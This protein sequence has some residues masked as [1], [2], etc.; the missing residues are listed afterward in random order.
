MRHAS[1]ALAALAAL[2]VLAAAPRPALADGHKFVV[3]GIQSTTKA[4]RPAAKVLTELVLDALL[5]RHGIRALGPSDIK[6]LLS[7]DAQKQLL[8][9]SDASCMATLGGAVN[10]DLVV[11]GQVGRLGKLYVVTLKL[12][13]AKDAKLLARSSAQ[14]KHLEEAAK[15]VGPLVDKLVGAPARQAQHLAVLG[16]PTPTKTAMDPRRFCPRVTRYFDQLAGERYAASLVKQRA[17]LL[18]DLMITRLKADF[19]EK[20]GCIWDREPRV[21]QPL[22][23]G[24]ERADT[25]AD[26]LDHRKRLAECLEMVRDLKR[27]EEAWTTGLEEAKH[28]TGNRPTALPFTV[29][30][31]ILSVPTHPALVKRLRHAWPRA[32]QVVAKAIAEAKAGH[33][34]RF[35]A[36]YDAEKDRTSPKYNLESIQGRLKNGY[37]VDPCPLFI[38]SGGQQDDRAVELNRRGLLRFC[39]RYVR[40]DWVNTDTLFLK[41]VKGR[42]RIDHW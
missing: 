14:L 20:R 8:G 7:V 38:F 18:E 10:A 1:A 27:V 42:W 17:A 23:R 15:V 12:L 19:D 24:I 28:G 34:G 35:T 40:K 11:T 31:G 25:A 9:C 30:P 36:L 32:Q 33:L 21:E 6:S 16:T 26:A 5:N 29:G 4:D 39:V 13:D 22:A 37:R 2:L 3:P 41:K